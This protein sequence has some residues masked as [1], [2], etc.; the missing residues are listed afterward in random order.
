ML[1]FMSNISLS[2]SLSLSLTHTHNTT[3]QKK[4]SV[5]KYYLVYFE[6]SLPKLPIKQNMFYTSNNTEGKKEGKN[7]TI[8]YGS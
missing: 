7:Q 3:S 4:I 1:C 6:Q 2:L 8:N 5:K